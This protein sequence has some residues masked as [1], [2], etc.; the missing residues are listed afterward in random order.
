MRVQKFIKYSIILIL[1]IINF[2][3][4]IIFYNIVQA[5]RY[6]LEWSIVFISKILPVIIILAPESKILPA[7]SSTG[8]QFGPI[9]IVGDNYGDENNIILH[10]L[11]HAK[12]DYKGL[13]I[14]SILRYKWSKKYRILSEYAAY[15]AETSNF[16]DD[17]IVEILFDDLHRLDMTREQIFKVIKEN[18]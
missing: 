3:S 17:V 1:C 4:T 14:F 2:I 7:I 13:F 6:K 10:E 5:E 11:E 15:K 9:I 8:G 16:R 18:K 12:Q